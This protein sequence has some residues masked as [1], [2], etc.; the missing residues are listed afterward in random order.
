MGSINILE[1][2]R[3]SIY[4]LIEKNREL[5]KQPASKEAKVIQTELFSVK[6]ELE[7][8]KTEITSKSEKGSPSNFARPIE[9]SIERVEGITKKVDKTITELLNWNR[10]LGGLAT[11]GISSAVFGHETEGSISLYINATDNARMLI[12]NSPPNIETAISELDKAIKHSK[13]VASWGAYALTRVQREKR[14]KKPINVKKTI[15]AVVKELR[16]AF[17]ASSIKL[18]VKGEPFVSRT[19]QMD[20]ESILIN[21]LTNA[22]TACNQKPG[23][24]HIIINVDREESKQSG[25]GYYFSVADTGPGIAKEF[26]NRIFEPLFSTKTVATGGSKSIGTGLGLTIVKSIVDDLNGTIR[27]DHDPELKGARLKIW[28][29]KE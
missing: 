28:L 11:I 1:T 19:Y 24:R 16:P 21:L 4:P 23:E 18:E 10:V 15:D 17:E 22:Y 27:V 25:T 14:S 5:R 12:K 8:I 13:K 9:K 6:E 20:I 2:H 26:I 7:S 29:P 3:A